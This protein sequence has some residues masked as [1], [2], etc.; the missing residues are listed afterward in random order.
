MKPL[1]LE[2]QESKKAAK[3]KN[4]T[5]KN[6]SNSNKRGLKLTKEQLKTKLLAKRLEQYAVQKKPSSP[7]EMTNLIDGVRSTVLE[8]N[9][10]KSQ[11]VKSSTKNSKQR[12]NPGNNKHPRPN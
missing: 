11:L 8:L 1:P 4:S 2:I 5:I 10:K 12:H 9:F 3:F 6:K 7:R